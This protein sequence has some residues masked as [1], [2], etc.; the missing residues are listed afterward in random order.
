MLASKPIYYRAFAVYG[1]FLTRI[2]TRRQAENIKRRCELQ[3]GCKA[4]VRYGYTDEHREHSTLIYILTTKYLFLANQI[5]NR[6]LLSF[7]V[8]LQKKLNE[9]TSFLWKVKPSFQFCFHLGTW[10]FCDSLCKCI[11]CCT[12]I[13]HVQK[14]GHFTILV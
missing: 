8:S 13:L 10:K 4:T 11:Y 3:F 14:S 9:E 12:V 5:N 2:R 6:L 7:H 1:Y